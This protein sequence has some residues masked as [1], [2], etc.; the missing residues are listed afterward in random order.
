MQF[1]LFIRACGLT[2]SR[3]AVLVLALAGCRPADPAAERTVIDAPTVS[4][5]LVEDLRLGVDEPF[6]GWIGDVAVD[7]S[8]SIYVSEAKDPTGIYR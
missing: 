5:E 4:V 8:G 2:V 6:F 7:A 1:V 3:L